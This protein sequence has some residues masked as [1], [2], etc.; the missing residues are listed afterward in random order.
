VNDVNIQLMRHLF[1]MASAA[2][3]IYQRLRPGGEVDGCNYCMLV[4]AARSWIKR[5]TYSVAMLAFSQ[6]RFRDHRRTIVSTFGRAGQRSRFVRST[7]P[8]NNDR[9][10]C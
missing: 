1:M 7:R 10:V 9:A 8:V 2:W 3:V 4:G 5:L 6:P